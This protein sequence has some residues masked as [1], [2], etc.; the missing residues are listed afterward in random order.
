MLFVTEKKENI[1]YEIQLIFSVI[2]IKIIKNV[3]PFVVLIHHFLL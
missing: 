2:T 1:S 3:I